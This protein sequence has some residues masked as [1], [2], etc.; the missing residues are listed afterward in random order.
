MRTIGE[1]LKFALDAKGDRAGTRFTASDLARACGVTRQAVS[2]WMLGQS[3]NI[4]PDNLVCVADW[5]GVEVRWLATGDGPML[6]RD[7]LTLDR[8]T[9]SQKVTLQAV[10]DSFGKPPVKSDGTEGR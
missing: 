3:T 2:Q 4:R 10:M 8:L 7:T 1:R 9:P 6:K 5:L